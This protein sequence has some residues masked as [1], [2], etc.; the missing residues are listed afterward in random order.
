[1]TTHKNMVL[2]VHFCLHGKQTRGGLR[3]IHCRVYYKGANRHI[4]TGVSIEA[5]IQYRMEWR[6]N[7][8]IE[9][10]NQTLRP[11]GLDGL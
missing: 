2:T 8:S 9:A 7:K 10:I 6:H 3:H 11:R 1:M 4:S 5:F